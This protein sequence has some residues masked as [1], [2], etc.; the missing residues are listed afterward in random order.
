MIATIKGKIIDVED[1]SITVEVGGVGYKVF[2]TTET[3]NT[4]QTQSEIS[5]FTHLAVREDSMDL[6]GFPSKNDK[7]L[8]ESLISVSGIGPK[9]A[10]NI[11]S[12][13]ST[14]TL[15]HGIQS[16]ST[17]HLIKV[18]GIG[19]KT[20]EKIVLEL[21]DKLDHISVSRESSSFASDADAIEALKMLGYNSEQARDSLKK[22][23]KN[24][25]DTG[26]KVKAA[27][28]ILN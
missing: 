1:R 12:T 2:V 22:I 16:G 13:V 15:I 20:A 28:K 9:G 6:Y 5:L 3:I 19:K 18:S 10:L 21:K 4:A 27:L 7:N 25:V 23:D 14:E 8:F 11:L 24:I 17:A 26:D